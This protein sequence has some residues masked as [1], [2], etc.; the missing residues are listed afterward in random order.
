MDRFYAR[1]LYINK[2]KK[3]K[4]KNPDKFFFTVGGKTSII[5][6]R[7]GYNIEELIAEE[8]IRNGKNKR[9]SFYCKKNC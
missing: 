5:I 4:L 6:K 8:Y 1:V 7:E 9:D 3:D 2:K